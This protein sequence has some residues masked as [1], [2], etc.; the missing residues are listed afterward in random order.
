MSNHSHTERED[1]V[2]FH[3]G[4]QNWVDAYTARFV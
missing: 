3:I 1:L 4:N 2:A